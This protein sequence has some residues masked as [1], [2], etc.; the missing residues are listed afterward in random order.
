M[1]VLYLRYRPDLIVVL[2]YNGSRLATLLNGIEVSEAQPP[3]HNQMKEE[4]WGFH[5]VMTRA[6]ETPIADAV[7]YTK[8]V[9]VT[10]IRCSKVPTLVRQ[11]GL[12]GPVPWMTSQ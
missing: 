12:V 2:W 7:E 8:L 1:E 4:K 5:L 6:S 10:V 3:G 11:L 9:P